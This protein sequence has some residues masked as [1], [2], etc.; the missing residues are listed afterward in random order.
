MVVDRV[1]VVEMVVVV[2]VEVVVVEVV[3][4]TARVVVDTR[5]AEGEAVVRDIWRTARSD[6]NKQAGNAMIHRRGISISAGAVER[7]DSRKNA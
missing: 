2:V 3:V 7:M 6:R 5:E 4:L 1:V